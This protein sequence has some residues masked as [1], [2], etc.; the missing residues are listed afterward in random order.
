MPPK[1][2]K[3]K[4]QGQAYKLLKKYGQLLASP[5]DVESMAYGEGMKFAVAP[6]SGC[7]AR[8]VRNAD[9]GGFARISDR[10]PE[11]GRVRFALAHELGHF[12]LHVGISQTR[13]CTAGDMRDYWKDGMEIEA[14]IFASELLLPQKNF[15][16]VIKLT[17]PSFKEIGAVAEMF[18]VSMTAAA[19]RYI[20]HGPI[21]DMVL[22]QIGRDHR[23]KWSKGKEG[24]TD[25]WIEP[26]SKIHDGSMAK[27]A[28]LDK[29]SVDETQVDFDV[30]FRGKHWIQLTEE[31]LYMPEYDSVLSLL[32]I[33]KS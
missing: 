9:G 16:E 2:D 22:V 7:E 12:L 6:L 27:C 30:W 29:S 33:S 1:V 13:A 23:V 4:A 15:K 26:G 17:G 20:D 19:I 24:N 5:V 25:Y 8:L 18:N 14:N 10:I 32:V 21:P 3:I 28:F 11:P 31:C